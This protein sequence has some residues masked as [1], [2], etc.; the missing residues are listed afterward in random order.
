MT[1]ARFSPKRTHH[2]IIPAL[3]P[4]QW[5]F[6]FF[7]I[8]SLFLT[9]RNSEAA[10]GFVS[11][12]LRL[13]AGTVIPS[14]FPFLVVSE[15]LVLSGTGEAI[16]QIL[17]GPFRKVFGVSGL[18]FTVF[19]L[20]SLCGFPV[21]AR[22][23]ISYY[24]RGLLGKKETER[25]LTF[26][27][28]PSSAFLVS[29][30]GVS[31]FGSQ[32]FGAILFGVTLLSAMLVGFFGKFFLPPDPVTHIPVHPAHNTRIRTGVSVFTDAVT[33]A[34][35]SMLRVCSYVIFFTALT[36]TLKLFLMTIHASDLISAA[37]TGVFE[38]T[39]GVGAAA[40]LTQR[41]I[42]AVLAAFFA[43]WSGLS[44]HMQIL[45][46]TDG[47]GLC[48]RPYFLA[49]FIQGMIAG[50]LMWGILKLFPELMADQQRA[51]FF[52]VPDTGEGFGQKVC[53]ATVT[54]FL[55]GILVRLFRRKH[56]K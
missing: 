5:F 48:Y 44:V 22:T 18:G 29:A 4:G 8:F 43:G 46:I 25:L 45:S 3:T 23:A 35:D 38:L 30:V 6:C 40:A 7:G 10:I 50:G 32:L 16:G 21:G 12:G 31:L 54:V 28:N 9:V 41:Q 33:N 1:N 42:G 34:A 26:T 17:S 19:F 27:N 39:T 36:G 13:C 56:K 24:D 14:L 20:G 51:V 11:D 47:R 55:I 2:G 52:S 53:I 15:L 37:L 49:K